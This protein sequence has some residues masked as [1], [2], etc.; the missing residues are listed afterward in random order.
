MAEEYGP[1]A[2]KRRIEI[3]ESSEEEEDE[4][5]CFIDLLPDEILIDIFELLRFEERK[6]CALVCHRWHLILRSNYFMSRTQC[7]L[8]HCFGMLI[9]PARQRLLSNCGHIYFSDS[10]SVP[11]ATDKDLVPAHKGHDQPGPS[12]AKP[13]ISLEDFLFSGKLPLRS[14]TVT[15]LCGRIITFVGGRLEQ[16]PQLEELVMN[17]VPPQDEESKVKWVDE[18]DPLW[19]IKHPRLRSLSVLLYAGPMSYTLEL[20]QLRKLTIE[21]DTDNELNA[22]IKYSEQLDELWVLFYFSRAMEQTLTYPFPALKKLNMKRYG[23]ND[24][25]DP[26]TRVDDAS[27]ERFVKSAPLLEDVTLRCNIATTRMLRAVCLIGHRSITRLT[28]LDVVLPRSLFAFIT[29]LKKLEFLKLKKCEVEDGGPLR[30]VDFPRLKQLILINSGTCIRID[31]GLSNVTHFKYS[32]DPKLS[33]ICHHMVQLEDFEIKL[34]T[35]YPVADYVRDHFHSLPNLGQLQTFRLS[36]MKT[37]NRPWDFCR[38]MPAIEHLVL[39]KCHLVR[40]DFS[41]LPKL[42]PSLRL[43]ELQETHIAYKRCPAGVDPL[44]H[45]HGRLK[46]FFPPPCRVVVDSSSCATPLA[47]VLEMEDEFRWHLNQVRQAGLIIKQLHPKAK[48]RREAARLRALIGKLEQAEQDEQ[49]AL[50]KQT[51]NEGDQKET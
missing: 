50:K 48:K 38:P 2:K 32:M 46:Q 31:R 4:L 10:G 5:E 12:S 3:V 27:A 33:K 29:E 17:I 15:A 41:K 13:G 36:G 19:T 34:R 43:L 45:F 37:V 51:K 39:R 20:P 9:E 23:A 8:Y 7:I 18:V 40:G 24:P 44:V 11:G 26:N 49:E 14:F 1:V 42:F 28:L 16:M 25:P 22:L 35:K 21:V 47:T 30:E 6:P